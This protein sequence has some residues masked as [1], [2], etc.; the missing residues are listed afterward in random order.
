MP[1]FFK[2]HFAEQPFIDGADAH[3]I[4]KSLRMRCGEELTVCDTKE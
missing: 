1:R 4:I 2:E 3:H